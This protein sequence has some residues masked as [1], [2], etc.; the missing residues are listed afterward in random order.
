MGYIAVAVLVGSG[1]V[2]SWFLVG[3]LSRLTETPYGQL[4]I[5]KL[6]L[7]AGMVVLAAWNR[8]WLVP[9]LVRAREVGSQHACLGRLRR[10][11]LGEQVLGSLILLIVSVL[12]TLH[13]AISTP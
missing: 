2:N 3:S 5:M 7:F 4:L 8:F 1:L 6:C 11:V 12:G 13:P 10:H 9:S